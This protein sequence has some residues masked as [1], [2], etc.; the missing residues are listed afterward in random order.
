MA[1]YNKRQNKKGT[2]YQ[3]IIRVTGYKTLCKTFKLKSQAQAWA[4]PIERAMKDG[5]YNET[6]EINCNNQT[7][8]INNVEELIQYFRK[9]VA[10]D[11]YSDPEKYNVMYDWWINHI[12]SV[13]IKNI[14]ASMISSCKEQLRTETIQ[15]G[16]EKFTTRGN[17]TINKYLMCLSAVLTYAVKELEIIEVNPCSKVSPMPKPKGRTRFLSIEEIASFL[18]ACKK[19]SLMVYIFALISIS[20]GA[21]YSEVLHLRTEDIDYHNMQVYYL[22]TKNKEHRGV[23]VEKELLDLIKK[24]AEDNNIESGNIFRAKRNDGEYPYIKGILEDIIKNLGLENFHIHDLR[25][26]TASYIAMNGGS[27][28][29]IAE[30]LGHKSLVMARRYSHLTKKHT[31][32]VLNKVTDKIIPEF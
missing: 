19:H 26:T 4:E 31:A 20:T 3:A 12:G 28:L 30:I 23:P 11:R 15:K 29:D 5:L 14:S 7:E 10:P 16:K 24:Y 13:K 2:C 9:N 27:L 21:R 32:S 25:H 22:N 6:L 8:Q 17:S 1:V 18:G